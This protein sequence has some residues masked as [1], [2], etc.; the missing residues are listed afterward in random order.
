LVAA[1]AAVTV[2][3]TAVAVVTVAETAVVTTVR[4]STTAIFNA[5]GFIPLFIQ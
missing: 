2:V 4:V 5:S 3:V 1:A